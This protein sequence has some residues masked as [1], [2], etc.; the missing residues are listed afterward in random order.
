M[1]HRLGDLA[2]GELQITDKKWESMWSKGAIRAIRRGINTSKATGIDGV[3][4]S[5]IK[6][7]PDV[8]DDVLSTWFKLLVFR[9]PREWTM[10]V[11]TLLHKGGYG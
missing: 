2:P 9:F 7:L 8:F 4:P 11:W 6:H 3:G 1:R 10:S 5:L